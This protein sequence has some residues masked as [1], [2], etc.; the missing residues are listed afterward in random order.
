[1][2]SLFVASGVAVEKCGLPELI[3][4][5]APLTLSRPIREC[6]YDSGHFRVWFDTTGVH[7]IPLR[8]SLPADGVPD[9]AQWATEYLER[10]RALLVDTLGYR[11]PIA[12]SST[13]SGRTDVG[14]DDRT[15]IY[16]TDMEFY[17]MTY[18]D[19]MLA[20]GVG[21]AFLT[22][23]NDYEE[24]SFPNYIG[25]EEQALAVTCAHEFF[26]AI[27]YAYG[28]NSS[29]T[30]WMEATAVWAEERVFP[31]VNDYLAYL[32]AFQASPEAGLN[33]NT[34]S[35]RFYGSCLF[36][37]FLSANYGDSAIFEI[38]SNIPSNNVYPAISLWAN[39]LG[40]NL[41]SLYG[42]F[43][44]WN[45]LVDD[46]YREYGYIDA[47]LMPKPKLT[48]RD[49]LPDN[50]TAA[51]GAVYISLPKYIDGGLWAEYSPADS[52]SAL[53]HSISYT[54]N[55]FSDTT[56]NIFNRPDTIPGTWRFD[57]VYT[58]LANLGTT[59]SSSARLGQILTG[60][61]PSARVPIPDD[62]LDRTPYPNPFIYSEAETL[63]IP[64]TS[65]G[66]FPIRFSVW[67]VAGELIYERVDMTTFGYHLTKRGALPWVP[68]NYTGKSLASG[69]YVYIL[70]IENNSFTGRF[71]IINDN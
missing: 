12:D 42:N 63:Y 8:D 57:G 58:V 24:A 39:D 61:A 4:S 15:D 21:P 18:L 28:S 10:A 52:I 66:E 62:V 43:A 55:D 69:V 19:T 50:L 41:K 13:F 46:N 25:R 33:N 36:P 23:E 27:H 54:G 60:P 35:G 7:A 59:P 16:F 14:G 49:S 68:Q 64:Y 34:P 53:L 67:N 2:L 31:H 71:A 3:M 45:L 5:K 38:W 44:L 40:I 70:S 56:L 20:G 48:H 65:S 1:M 29:W 37:M 9:W 17:G 51:G 47:P 11:H 6:S 22:I 32:T 26:H 30:W